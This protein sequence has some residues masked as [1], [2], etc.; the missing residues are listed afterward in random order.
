MKHPSDDTLF[1]NLGWLGQFVLLCSSSMMN[2]W[3]ENE[4]SSMRFLNHLLCRPLRDLW[5]EDP[6]ELRARAGAARWRPVI[7]SALPCPAPLCSCPPPPCPALCTNQWP[8]SPHTCL[9]TLLRQPALHAALCPALGNSK[10]VNA[11]L[12]LMRVVLLQ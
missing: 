11:V 9:S 10:A 1:H 3:L 12:D 2:V 6:P 8:F 5:T 7:R 4:R